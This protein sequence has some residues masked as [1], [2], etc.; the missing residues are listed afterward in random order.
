MIKQEVV[1]RMVAEYTQDI[2]H[3]Y[4]GVSFHSGYGK[5]IFSDG[6]KMIITTADAQ[7]LKDKHNLKTV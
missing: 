4:A 3:G 5:I 2:Q 1:K 7:D 6:V